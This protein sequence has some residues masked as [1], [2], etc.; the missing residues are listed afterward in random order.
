MKKQIVLFALVATLAVVTAVC[1]QQLIDVVEGHKLVSARASPASNGSPQPLS[2]R[3]PIVVELFT[4]EGCSS[5]PPADDV[6]SRL[7]SEQPIAGAQIIALSQH[8]DY[9]ND[10]GWRDPFSAAG[11]SERQREYAGVFRNRGVYTP[12]MVVDG[13]YEFVGNNMSKARDAIAQAAQ[14]PKAAVQVQ[15]DQVAEGV[16][17]GHLR[18]KVTVDNLQA[19]KRDESADVLLAVTESNLR[20]SVSNGENAGRRLVH[21]AVVRQLRVIGDLD[22]KAQGF[23]A[24]PTIAFDRDWKRADLR[25]VV[26]AQERASRRII[27]AGVVPLPIRE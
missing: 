14:S 15:L 12:Q 3:A 19:V 16:A 24:E 4:S 18:F 22:V 5:C 8:V 7:D 17:T 23:T 26:F 6:L 2:N 25:V 11:F 27:G 9:W 1:V 13:R 10:L 21:S 20:S